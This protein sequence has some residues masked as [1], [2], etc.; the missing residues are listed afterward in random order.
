MFQCKIC[1][2]EFNS[3]SGLNGHHR[4]HGPSGGHYEQKRT[5]KRSTP[6]E[7][8][9]EFNCLNCGELGFYYPSNSNGKFCSIKCQHNYNWKTIYVPIIE[10]GKSTNK[11]H[12]KKYLK[13]QIGDECVECGQLPIHNNKPLTLQL[14]H[15]DGNS[16]NNLLYNLRLLC[17][18]CHTQTPTFCSKK[19]IKNKPKQTR[20]NS[21]LRQYQKPAT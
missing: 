12:L 17:P 21:Y 8:K 6:F 14:D 11:H 13:E 1:Q 7:P 3:R 20:R 18:N 9:A 19:N 2:K 16:D 4:V 10:N 5:V 15:I